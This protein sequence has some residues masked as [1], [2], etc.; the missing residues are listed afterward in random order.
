M[1]TKFFAKLLTALY[2]LFSISGITHAVTLQNGVTFH[3][4][5]QTSMSIVH[6]N[7]SVP[8]NASS[9]AVSISN[10]S[11]DLDLY[12]KYG[13]PITGTTISQIESSADKFTTSS[14]ANENITITKSTTPALQSGTWY[15]SVINWNQT[16]TSYD[17]LASISIAQET[18]NRAGGIPSGVLIFGD[19]LITAIGMNFSNDFD[20][21]TVQ[22]LNSLIMP[23][24]A[25]FVPDG[26]IRV[27]S[28]DTLIGSGYTGESLHQLL[29]SVLSDLEAYYQV[30]ITQVSS[31]S[32]GVITRVDIY[33][34]NPEY[35]SGQFMGAFEIAEDIPLMDL[36]SLMSDGTRYIKIK[37]VE[38]STTTGDDFIRMEFYFQASTSSQS[39]FIV[40]A[41]ITEI[42]IQ[43][44]FSMLQASD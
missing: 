16:T 29:V 17:L 6:F 24:M 35:P 5:S 31:S 36:L 22:D 7:F 9:F 23:L 12:L 18:T 41:E 13:S 2:L 1:K 8:S 32:L 40:T 21:Q 28:A 44:A 10:G 15:V 26:L 33:L 20:L 37:T 14:I 38:S 30:N 42:L 11:G 25:N 4:S 39:L 3:V 27:Y 19:N 34:W 43:K